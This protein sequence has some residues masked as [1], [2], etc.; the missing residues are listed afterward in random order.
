VTGSAGVGAD[1]LPGAAEQ[2]LGCYLAEIAD[3]LIGPAG[4]RRD[5]LS[6][7]GAGLA[8]ATDRRH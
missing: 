2:V 3:R 1:G 6:E 5:I 7:L 8:D 4:A